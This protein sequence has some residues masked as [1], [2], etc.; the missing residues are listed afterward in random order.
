M[1]ALQLYGVISGRKACR[2]CVWH[3][4]LDAELYTTFP[5]KRVLEVIRFIETFQHFAHQ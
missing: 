3:I 2:D 5:G 1:Y 4:I